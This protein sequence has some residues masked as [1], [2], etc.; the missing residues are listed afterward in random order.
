M[1]DRVVDPY[2]VDADPD[3]DPDLT[4]HSDADPDSEFYLML[5]LIPD[6]NPNFHL[7]RI[8]ILASKQRLKPLK[9]CSNRLIFHTFWLIICKLMRTRFRFRIQLITLMFYYWCGCGSKSSLAKWWGSMRIHNTR[10]TLKDK[11]PCQRKRLTLIFS[12]ALLEKNLALTMT[13]CLGR[14]PLPST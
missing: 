9:T 4:Y 13:G 6:S 3:A 8:Q 14:T 10:K 11:Q 5:M 12:S 2:H 1:Y 7:I